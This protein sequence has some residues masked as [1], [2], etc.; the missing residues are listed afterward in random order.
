MKP[1]VDFL[2]PETRRCPFPFYEELH[3]DRPV[4]W[5][6]E[7]GMYVVS[8][9]DLIM[10][11]V[12]D[13]AT[14]SSLGT[15]AAAG[16]RTRNNYSPAADELLAREG[17][18]RSAPTLVNNDAPGHTG[19]RKLIAQTFR[20]SRVR[21]MEPYVTGTVTALV[22]AIRGKAEVD[23]ASA[24]ALPLPT[25]VIADQLGVA[26]DDL[27]KFKRWTE[28]LLYLFRPPKTED[29]LLE[30]ARQLAQMHQ[31][32]IRRMAERRAQPQ[33]DII[34][35]LVNDTL[36]G[37][38]KL[39][40]REA[41]SMIEQ[42]LVGGI[43]TTASGIASGLLRLA[44]DQTLQA[45][46]RADPSKVKAFVE[47]ILRM[48]APAQGLV[49]TTTREVELGGVTIPPDATVMVLYGAANRDE[50]HFADAGCLRLDRDNG[51]SH[52]AFGSGIHH[53]IGSELAR[54]EMRAAFETFLRLIPRFELAEPEESLDYN[55]MFTVRGLLHLRLKLS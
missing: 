13:P 30:D 9:Y 6:A 35:D 42:L 53:C 21:Q 26:R 29:E 49:R 36:P 48:D 23:V 34:S 28:A 44:T 25:Y 12:R 46:L 20:V 38:E 54:V 47:E 40:D 5:V 2:S 3:R 31:Y 24:I 14:F 18:G 15:K 11:V 51:G 17:L 52:L 8:T 16:A 10:Q 41:M 4:A 39:T 37:G 55:P 33:D 19:Y 32:M 27:E 7:I 45:D 43:E 50:S 22:E 1:E